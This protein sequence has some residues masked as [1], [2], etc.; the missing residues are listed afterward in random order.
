MRG[1]A[2]DGSETNGTG[3]VERVLADLGE[4]RK[5]APLC[6]VT[7]G[8]HGNE[9]AGIAA[10]RRVLSRS[11]KPGS[12]LPP[13]HGRFLALS[14]NR[15]GLARGVRFV[16]EDMNRVWSA[17]RVA[18][19]LESAAG[20]DSAEMSEQRDLLAQIERAIATSPSRVTHLDLHSTSGA[21]PPFTVIAGPES[22]RAAAN[23]LGV[24]LLLGLE[25]VIEG[26]LIEYLGGLG[27]STVLIE[28][29]QNE[30]DT[31]VDHHEA[32]VWLTLVHSGVVRAEDVPDLDAMRARLDEGSRGLPS[33]LEIGY[34]HRLEPDEPF[35]MLPGYANFDA[36][37]EGQLLAR[38]GPDYVR[39]VRAPWTGTL[40]MPRY[41][42]QGL[43]GFF[44]ARRVG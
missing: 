1:S 21:G 10:L 33:E 20:R 38:A 3:T 35:R 36:V 14:G 44:L 32:A 6:I 7:A 9:P 29:G 37:V 5:G 30:A 12:A 34:C 26:T 4:G 13:L 15:G 28:G 31:T 22:S 42:G 39:E 43:D 17:E 40:V 41:Q 18:A 11:T 23:N 8:I 2:T 16:D 19:L 27:H 24:P 25:D